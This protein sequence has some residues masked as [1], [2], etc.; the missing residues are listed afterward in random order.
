MVKIICEGKTDKNF[1]KNFLEFLGIEI[2]DDNFIVMGNK[3]NIF[4]IDNKEYKTLV[5]LIKAEKIEKVLFIVDS[6]YQQDNAK[7]GGYENTQKEIEKLLDELRIREISDY[8]ISCNP[9]TK[10][11]YLESLILSTI[12]ENLKKCYMEF[13]DCIE[14]K[15]KNHHKYIVTELHK[16]TKPNKPYNFN[17]K[18]FDILK[19]KLIK[20]FKWKNS[21]E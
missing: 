5:A 13:L 16:L 4:K 17:H 10:E 20:M 19:E 3:S 14:F 1:I 9:T 21:K 8:F 7:F 18:N 12:D 15:E 2:S 11:G 6:D